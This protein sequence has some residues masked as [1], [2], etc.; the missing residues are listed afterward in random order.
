MTCSSSD[1]NFNFLNRFGSLVADYAITFNQQINVASLEKNIT[2]ALK[3]ISSFEKTIGERTF[4]GKINA[5]KS[6]T[7]TSTL[8]N[9]VDSEAAVRRC[10]SNSYS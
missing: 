4:S 10:S 3:T 7:G 5:T 6:I 2:D 8:K 1:L 9:L